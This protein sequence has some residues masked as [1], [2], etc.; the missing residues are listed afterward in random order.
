[1]GPVARPARSGEQSSS[2]C[3]PPVTSWQNGLHGAAHRPQ[4]GDSMP[5]YVP[6]PGTAPSPASIDPNTTRAL[7][8]LG[9]PEEQEE[10]EVTLLLRENPEGQSLDQALEAIAAEPP[11][12]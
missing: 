1:M 11:G 12:S 8:P 4:E 9:E 2:L 5:D 6:L 3:P 7:G 10:V